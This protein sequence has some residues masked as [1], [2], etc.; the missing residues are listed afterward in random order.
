MEKESDFT[1]EITPE[2]EAGEPKSLEQ[3]MIEKA[4][5]K[6]GKIFPCVTKSNLNECF[7]VEGSKLVFWFNTEDHSTQALVED[8]K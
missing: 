3:K 6:Y 4:I 7:T 5:K 2:K 8:I 1:P